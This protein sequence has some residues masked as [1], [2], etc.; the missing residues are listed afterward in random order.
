MSYRLDPVAAISVWGLLW[1]AGV[2]L[3]SE[4]A[5]PASVL[6][7][8][9]GV[10][11]VSL[12]AR[13]R[14]IPP[15]FSMAATL[16]LTLLTL[17]IA[18]PGYDLWAAPLALLALPRM[19]RRGERVGLV[20]LLGGLGLAAW[21][22]NFARGVL[23]NLDRAEPGKAAIVRLAEEILGAGFPFSALHTGCL[24]ATTTITLALTVLLLRAGVGAATAAPREPEGSSRAG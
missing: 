18:T 1:H 24:V 6:A 23:Q 14:G 7:C 20:A 2:Q 16:Y 10:L 15:V 22:A 19:G 17:S 8:G 5:Q 4:I 11:G 13:Q 9:L 3:P 21:G 12:F